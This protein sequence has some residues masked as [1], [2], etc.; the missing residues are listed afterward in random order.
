M[1]DQ[2]S[3]AVS[4]GDP[5]GDEH[6]ARV[7]EYLKS[8]LPGLQLWGMGGSELRERG[9]ETVVDSEVSASVMGV[10]DVILS[11]GKIRSAFQKLTSELKKRRPKLLILVDYQEFNILLAK[12]A[13]QLGIP[14]LFFIGPTVW[15]WRRGRVKRFQRHVDRLALIFPF[16]RSFFEE[17]GF[18]RSV[19]VGHPFS[20][21]FK[22]LDQEEREEFAEKIGITL[23]NPVLALLP[24]SRR[25]EIQQ[26][27]SVLLEAFRLARQEIPNL[28]GVIP[29]P[30]SIPIDRLSSCE[31]EPGITL[32]KG[33]SLPIM[34]IAS[35][36]II[37]SGTSNLQAVFCDLPFSM[38]YRAGLLVELTV[39][40]L[41]ERRHFSIVNIIRPDTIREFT[42]E[43]VTADALASE[44]VSLLLDEK[45]RQSVLENF[46]IVRSTLGGCDE[47]VGFS[48]HQS[49]YE[50]VAILAVEMLGGERSA[51]T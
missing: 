17:H 10:G 33:Q 16:E 2:I 21:K 29:V 13:K 37:K 9:V 42:Q 15:A 11:L 46:Q 31:N 41:V 6:A 38:I 14:T 36:G 22:P 18:D 51:S 5:S 43:T 3:I 4:A 45:R 30:P 40:L 19:Y 24:G 25:R 8:S 23:T 12:K 44:M 35:A 7:V 26:H 48:G 47:H 39:R 27:L 20:A 50:R 34:Q 28:Q 1:S 49:P 32:V